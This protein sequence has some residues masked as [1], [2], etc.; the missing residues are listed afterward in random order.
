[1]KS[2]NAVGQNIS[3]LGN[4][5]TTNHNKKAVQTNTKAATILQNRNIVSAIKATRTT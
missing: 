3:T 5:F 2:P 4:A 1:M